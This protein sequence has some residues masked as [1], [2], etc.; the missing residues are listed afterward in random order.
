MFVKPGNRT[1]KELE[2]AVPIKQKPPT[3]MARSRSGEEISRVAKPS[4]LRR[5][6]T[7]M[8]EEMSQLAKI[9]EPQKK[10]KSEL[11][12]PREETFYDASDALET[13]RA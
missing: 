5:S 7:A 11:D 12:S 13:S 2:S 4:M 8:N 1:R 3:N 6:L 10:P 9:E